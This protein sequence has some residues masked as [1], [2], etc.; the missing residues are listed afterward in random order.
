MIDQEVLASVPAF[1]TV[2]VAVDM[3]AIVVMA[4]PPFDWIAIVTDE[5]LKIL[6]ASPRTNVVVAGS[7]T[8]C[9]AVE[10]VKY[11][12]AAEEAVRVKVDADVA[13]VA[14]PSIKLLAVKFLFASQPAKDEA[15][16]VAV[17]DVLPAAVISPLPLTV[18]L[19]IA[20]PEPKEP[21]FVLTVANVRAE[22][23]GPVAVPSPVSAVIP[24]LPVGAA[25]EPSARKK[26][27][28]PPP[29]E[30]TTPGCVESNGCNVST[31]PESEAALADG[32]LPTAPSVTSPLFVLDKLEPVTVPVAATDDGVIAPS[33]KLIAGVLVA[34]ATVPDIPLAVVTDTEVTVPVP[35][36][37]A[38]HVPSALKKLDVPPPEA[39]AI[40]CKEDV[41][42]LR[43]AVSWVAVISAGFA[44][45]PVLFPLYVWAAMVAILA[46]VTALELMAVAVCVP[47]MSPDREPVKFVA[48][49]ADVAVEALPERFAVIVPAEKFPPLSR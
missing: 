34:V 5:L 18:K 3:D 2:Y 45:V 7:L 32:E 30:L 31:W 16:G 39:G 42:W 29:E 41:N 15:V 43:S 38:A 25:H 49:E 17:E 36:G 6:N 20:V 11:W 24:E 23:P 1:V 37:G 12:L 27:D 44:V 8:I 19:G 13:C 46:L 26:L 9:E 33:V 22:D 21:V 35:D 10:P 47:V 28:V 14:Y 40:P 4:V 48:D